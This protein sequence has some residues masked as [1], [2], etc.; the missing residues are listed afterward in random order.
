[1]NIDCG[2]SYVHMGSDKGRKHEYGILR[3]DLETRMDIPQ[4][5]FYLLHKIE[6]M[7]IYFE[8]CS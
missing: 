2:S 8:H 4:H 3:R 1:M 6:G 5:I 7:G